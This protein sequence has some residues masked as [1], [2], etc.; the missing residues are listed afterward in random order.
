MTYNLA[1]D[2]QKPVRSAKQAAKAEINKLFYKNL[3]SKVTAKAGPGGPT[4][5]KSAERKDEAAAEGDEEAADEEQVEDAPLDHQVPGDGQG[6]DSDDESGGADESEAMADFDTTNGEDPKELLGRL[7]QITLA[8]DKDDVPRWINRLEIHMESYGVEAQW[9]KRIVLE[10]NLPVEVQSQLNELFDKR[11]TA[12]GAAIYKECKTLLLKLYGPKPDDSFRQAQAVVMT[13]TPSKAAKQIL[14]L[15]CDKPTKLDSCCCAK[16]VSATWRDVLPTQVRAQIAAL[17]IN[18][19]PTF[20]TTIDTADQIYHELKVAKPVAAVKAGPKE[21]DPEVA[22]VGRGQSRG[23]RRGANRGGASRGGARG[24]GAGRG[25]AR[26]KRDP[27]D[28]STWGDPHADG[29]PPNA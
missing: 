25:G 1:D 11:K 13:D 4:P 12:A 19:L 17:D 10:R 14:D 27:N 6:G 26:P 7:H 24:G 15:I 5:P 28:R 8:Y 18:S 3:G 16:T 22:T 23:G 21:S 9:S 29:P 20:K 2:D